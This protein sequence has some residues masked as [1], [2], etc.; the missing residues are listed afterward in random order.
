[1]QLHMDSHNNYK[2]EMTIQLYKWIH[3]GEELENKT[4]YH[5]V[6]FSVH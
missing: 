2:H 3:K 1:M 4:T 5:I 6:T